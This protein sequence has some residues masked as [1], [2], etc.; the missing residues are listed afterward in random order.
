MSVHITCKNE[1]EPIKN[2]GKRGVT[3]LYIEFSDGQGQLTPQFQVSSSRILNP[4]EAL[5]LFSLSAK[6]KKIQ[7]KLKE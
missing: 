1:E 6:M 3:T 2:E 5:Q 4:S 7:L